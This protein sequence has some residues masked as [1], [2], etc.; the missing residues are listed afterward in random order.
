MDGTRLLNCVLVGVNGVMSMAGAAVASRD[1]VAL[2][3]SLAGAVGI[4]VLEEA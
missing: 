3:Y 2:A 1:M 4:T